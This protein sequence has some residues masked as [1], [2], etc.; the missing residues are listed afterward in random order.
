SYSVVRRTHEI[1]VRLALGAGRS[2]VRLMVMRETFILI[3]CGVALG[4]A[5]TYALTRQIQSMLFGLQPNDPTTI[6]MAIGIMTVI[7]ALAAYFP[8]RRASKV[9]P[10]VALRHE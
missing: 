4:L 5:G 6:G 2:D 10:V 7:A 8:A 9:D 3:V 1:G